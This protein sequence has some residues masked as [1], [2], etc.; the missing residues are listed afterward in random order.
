MSTI[1]KKMDQGEYDYKMIGY[2][3]DNENSKIQLEPI[4]ERIYIE[5]YPIK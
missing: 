4:G 5:L 2:E 3:W 1:I